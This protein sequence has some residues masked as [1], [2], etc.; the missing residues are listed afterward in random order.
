MPHASSTRSFPSVTGH[1]TGYYV[2]GPNYHP[3]LA[4]ERVPFSLDLQDGEDGNFSGSGADS[5]VSPSFRPAQ[6]E[7]NI[8]HERIIFTKEYPEAHYVD[9][10]GTHITDK[11]QPGF[12]ILYKGSWN[13]GEAMFRGTWKIIVPGEGIDEPVQE[14]TWEMV[15][16]ITVRHAA[17]Q[18]TEG[19]RL[20]VRKEAKHLEAVYF[21]NGWGN[22]LLHPHH[23]NVLLVFGLLVLLAVY[24]LWA[25]LTRPQAAYLSLL[26]SCAVFGMWTGY[27]IGKS[28]WQ[29][30][31]WKRE[32]G[33]YANLQAQAGDIELVLTEDALTQDSWQSDIT[34][35][36]KQLSS[37]NIE[38]DH[39]FLATNSAEWIFPKASM[40]EED[41]K[42]L[43]EFV[44][45]YCNSEHFTPDEN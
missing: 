36:W 11:T 8:T 29:V 5:D 28:M 40:N 7:G 13:E 16:T 4:G 9:E 26:T 12:S 1:W 34:I 2:Y 37:W 17:Q 18:V 35:F 42:V 3:S 30:Q 14:G 39:V 32:V 25:F 19:I 10:D 6:I 45:K 41:F 21:K 24:S 27:L 23:R 43:S 20:I 31:K 15:M 22:L 33:Q 44:R 38:A